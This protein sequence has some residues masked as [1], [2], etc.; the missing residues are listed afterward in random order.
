MSGMF[1]EKNTRPAPLSGTVSDFGSV[2]REGGS[3]RSERLVAVA[4]SET[5]RGAAIFAH[6]GVAFNTVRLIVRPTGPNSF[7]VRFEDCNRFPSSGQQ[8]LSSGSAW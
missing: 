3:E 7:T 8:R 5:T 4:L 6:Y 2:I 1:R